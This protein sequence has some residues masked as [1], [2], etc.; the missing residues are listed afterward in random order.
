MFD[1]GIA[2]DVVG[3]IVRQGE[4]IASYPDD[5]PYPGE[6]LIGFDDSR[7]I[8]VLV[9]RD[10]QSG[11]CHVVTAYVADPA[12]WDETFRNRRLR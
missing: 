3:R 4:Q 12:L 7:P 2:P 6:L 11:E 1:R 9:A 10:P 8:H 5:R